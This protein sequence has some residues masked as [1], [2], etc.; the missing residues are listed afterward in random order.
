MGSPGL[1]CFAIS[2]LLMDDA[3]VF[4]AIT[5][6]QP[7]DSGPPASRQAAVCPKDE[8]IPVGMPGHDGL[9]REKQ[10]QRQSRSPVGMTTRKARAKHSRV[11]TRDTTTLSLR[12]EGGAPRVSRGGLLVEI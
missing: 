7:K 3:S 6:S 12:A 5:R 1:S 4:T 9:A 8:C 10:K 11:L 2:G